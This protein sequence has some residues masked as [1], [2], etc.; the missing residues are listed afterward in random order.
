MTPIARK[1]NSDS[2]S[3]RR[4][5]ERA[6]VVLLQI[7]MVVLLQISMTSVHHRDPGTPEPRDA[8]GTKDLT[9]KIWED[10]TTG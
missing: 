7:S 10:L 6:S 3:K 2:V 1:V 5:C 9:A 4:V 8:A